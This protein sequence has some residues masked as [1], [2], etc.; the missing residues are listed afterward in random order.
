M[1]KEYDLGGTAS[2]D[3]KADGPSDK[4]NY[5]ANLA[6]KDVTAKA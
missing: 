5:A 2:F 6:M 4:L 1:L 3:A